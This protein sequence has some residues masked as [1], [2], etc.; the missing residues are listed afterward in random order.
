MISGARIGSVWSAA[1][2]FA[3]AGALAPV[4]AADRRASA[5]TPTLIAFTRGNPDSP[6][7]YNGHLMVVDSDGTGLRSLT[8]DGQ[9]EDASPAW[10]PDGKRIAFARETSVGRKGS[11]KARSWLSTPTA[12]V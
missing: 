10:S 11:S 3:F 5:T 2:V 7:V 12:P 8:D 9:Y 4:A 6:D 1:V